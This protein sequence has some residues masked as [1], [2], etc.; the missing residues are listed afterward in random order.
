VNTEDLQKKCADSTVL[1]AANACASTGAG[2]DSTVTSKFENKTVEIVP[3][4]AEASSAILSLV[5]RIPEV[6]NSRYDRKQFGN[7]I[8]F[9]LSAVAFSFYIQ[10]CNA[11]H[12]TPLLMAFAFLAFLSMLF[13]IK[14]NA[15]YFRSSVSFSPFTRKLFRFG[16]LILP[17]PFFIF[18][19]M[20][21][22][23]RSEIAD[24][25]RDYWASSFDS[26]LQHYT[27]AAWLAPRNSDA[28]IGQ[29]NVYYSQEKYAQAIE[30]A[31][32]AIALDA[33]NSYGWSDK[34]RAQ[35]ALDSTSEDA[36]NNAERAIGLDNE[37]GQAFGALSELYLNTK[38]LDK[39]LSAANAH[40]R[41]HGDEAHALEVRADILD[42][43][44]RTDEAAADR[45]AM[46][47]K[48]H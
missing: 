35:L 32:K 19:A 28:Y 4:T 5:P 36:I 48:V 39:A 18:G 2:F 8:Y 13:A 7:A 47:Q 34:A 30:I 33:G 43:L 26:S 46:K 9:M 20:D 31:D 37:N 38:S 25:Y 1:R 17:I 44:G 22:A 6:R 29:S 24:G 11:P 15:N 21:A 40:V 42:Q 10:Q 16:A 27:K 41:I 23:A 12:I 3:D 45:L 14:P